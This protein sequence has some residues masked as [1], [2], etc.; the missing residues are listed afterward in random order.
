MLRHMAPTGPLAALAFLTT[1]TFSRWASAIQVAS[2][3]P[4]RSLVR[5][6]YVLAFF[7]DSLTDT[8]N[9]LR[10]AGVPDPAVYYKGRYTDGPNWVD[11]LKSTLVKKHK[12]KVFNYAY[13]GATACPSPLISG[14][15]PF[16]K[17][18]SNQTE[19]FLADLKNGRIP[20]GKDVKTLPIQ[21]IGSNDVTNTLGAAMLSGAALDAGQV[22]SLVRSIA[23]CRLQWAKTLSAAGMRDIV[24]LPMV[25]MH[26]AP[27]VPAAYKPLVLQ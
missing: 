27:K 4:P 13:G 7:G 22:Q 21:Y 16:V 8:G 5:P 19:A 10:V 20:Y 2:P 1:V 23:A 14:T 17:D 15:Y 11:R 6:T 12:V 24:M 26:M 9:T 3:P 18:L 25:P